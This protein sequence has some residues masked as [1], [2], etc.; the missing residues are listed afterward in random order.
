M[1]PFARFRELIEDGVAAYRSQLDL[2]SDHPVC[3]NAPDRWQLTAWSVVLEEEGHQLPHIHETGWLS[4]VYYPKLPAEV[5][6]SPDNP[7]GWIEFGQPQELYNART[8]PP[9]R[10]IKPK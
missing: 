9:L 6:Q 1:G 5:G 2:S 8:L 10:L 7:S 3:A 4:G